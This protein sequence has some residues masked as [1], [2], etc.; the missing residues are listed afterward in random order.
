[1]QA[2]VSSQFSLNVDAV[3]S[4]VQLPALPVSVSVV[5]VLQTWVEVWRNAS[6]SEEPPSPQAH[7]NAAPAPA[8]GVARLAAAVAAEQTGSSTAARVGST[9]APL[10]S[11]VPDQAAVEA[12]YWDDVA[13]T[14]PARTV[15]IWK[16]L[17]AGLH[18][19]RSVLVRRRCVPS[20]ALYLQCTCCMIRSSACSG[21]M[22]DVHDLEASN[23]QLRQLLAQ[24]MSD[25]ANS[26]LH[27]PPAAT[28]RVEPAA[29]AALSSTVT[30]S[31]NRGFGGPGMRFSAGQTASAVSSRR[32]PH[33]PAGRTGGGITNGLYGGGGAGFIH[34]LGGFSGSA[35]SAVSGLQEGTAALPVLSVTS[36]PLPVT[37]ITRK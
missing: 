14:I 11:T 3:G 13:H 25:P 35:S 1:L 12:A 22:S 28:L 19:Y 4:R 23:A 10:Q 29:L 32:M 24:Y 8:L 9:T 26:E 33:A 6:S 18:K 17:D 34:G 27:V 16:A 20:L 37:S 36:S 30:A 31:S 15:R 2:V 7:R 21:L 5:R